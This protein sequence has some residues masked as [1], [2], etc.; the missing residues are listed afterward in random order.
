MY[1]DKYELARKKY[2]RFNESL[3][4]I[5]DYLQ[6]RMPGETVDPQ[7]VAS[8]TGLPIGT[9][10]CLLEALSE[11]KVGELR[12]SVVDAHGVELNSY[13]KMSEIP[14]SVPQQVGDDL[15]VGPE[16]VELVFEI[17]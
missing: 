3:T 8:S 9:V 14:T 17:S 2:P 1:S 6:D 11:V 10:I 12:L 15:E 16:N 13:S 7:I 5:H 4:R